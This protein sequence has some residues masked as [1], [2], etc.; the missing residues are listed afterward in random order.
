MSLFSLCA[1][2]VAYL[3]F[4]YVFIPQLYNRYKNYKSTHSRPPLEGEPSELFGLFEFK[5]MCANSDPL[6]PRYHLDIIAIHGLNGN[7]FTTGLTKRIGDYGSEIFYQIRSPARECSP[8][9]MTQ[10]CSVTQGLVSHDLLVIYFHN[11]VSC[12]NKNQLVI[13]TYEAICEPNRF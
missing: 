7:K 3:Y 6:K 11:Y 1:N 5:P 9:D 2:A 10:L 13:C 4:A 12:D 8:S